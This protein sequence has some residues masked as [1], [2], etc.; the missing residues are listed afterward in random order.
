MASLSGVATAV[1]IHIRRGEDINAK[2]EKG[3]SPLL[4]AASKGH[5]DVCRI[6]LDAGADPVSTDKNGNSPLSIALASNLPALVELFSGIDAGSSTAKMGSSQLNRTDSEEN[7]DASDENEADFD[8]TLWESEAEAISP[9][10][11]PECLVGER[12]VQR[13]ISAHTPIDTD[14]DWIDV[15]IDLPEVHK[16]RRRRNALDEEDL[17]AARGII[18]A[19]LQDGAV[20]ESWILSAVCDDDG[21]LDEEFEAKLRIILGDLGIF[22]DEAPIFDH[23]YDSLRR[24]REDVENDSDE[25]MSFLKELTYQD[26]DPLKLYFKDMAHDKLLTREDEVNIAILIENGLEQAIHSLASSDSAINEVLSL[27]SRVERGELQVSF[28]VNRDIVPQDDEV[29]QDDLEYVSE[30]LAL[31]EVDDNEEY[32]QESIAPADFQTR[33]DLLRETSVSTSQDKRQRLTGA[34]KDLN[35]SWSFLE[36]LR[37][38]LKESG[39][40]KVPLMEFSASLAKARDAKWRMTTANLKLVYSI[41]KKYLRRGLLLSDL[42]QEGNIGLMKAVEKFDHRRG[43]KFSTYATWWIRQAITRAIADQARL[44]RVPV[45]MVEV[46]NQINRFSEDIEGKT[47]SPAELHEISGTLCMPVSKVA[48]A[49]LANQE[50]VDLDEKVLVDGRETKVEETLA[51]EE[52]GPLEYAFHSALKRAIFEAISGLSK[53][54]SEVI[55][56][57][58]GLGSDVSH[59]LEECGQIYGVTRERIRQIEAKALKKLRHPE[60]SQKLATFK[61]EMTETLEDDEYPQ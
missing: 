13:Q 7:A 45:H 48:K 61:N 22:I 36:Y 32:T 53:R 52:P 9:L 34:L 40:D 28:M 23:E 54:E 16:S 20:P 6:L 29:S 3:R 39:N 25:A 10:S 42:I 60:R 50:V 55:E 31:E 49:L 38:K 15:E 41:A 14:F 26:D 11:D 8:P 59:T 35:L 33:I 30:A 43:F 56:L 51:E 2:D 37:G 27:A 46:I 44:I 21:E 47:G 4:L 58:F 5:V 1:R 18:L 24:F 57:R 17:I 19:G 12:V